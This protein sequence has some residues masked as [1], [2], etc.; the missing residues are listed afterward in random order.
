MAN[1]PCAGAAARRRVP[2]AGA[3]SVVA[4]LAFASPAHALD[5]RFEPSLSA[6]AIYTDNINQSSS[7]PQDGL[8]LS[9]TPGF[10]LQSKGSRRVQ[11]S[12]QY[13]LSGVTRFGGNQSDNFYHNL[14][15]VGKAELARDFLFI[16]GS[17]HI[18]QQ[19]ISLLG[20]PAD[21]T[22]NN[23]NRATVGTY[24]ISPYLQRRLGTFANAQMRYTASGAIFDN[25]AV[26]ANNSS[27]NAVTAGLASGTRFDDLTWGLDYSLRKA[28]YRS[29]ASTTFESA[30]ARLGYALTRK[31]RVFGTV[32]H[33]WNDYPS[34]TATSGASYSA[35]F[36]WAPSRRTSVEASAGKRYFGNTYSLSARHRTRMSNWN[37]SYSEDA[38]DITQFLFT[39]GTRYNYLCPDAQGNPQIITDWPYSFPPSSGCLQFGGTPGLMFDLRSGVFIARTARAGVSWGI[40]KVTYSLNY[41]DSRRMFVAANVEDRTQSLGATAIYRMTP[42]T[43]L[44]GG[45]TLTRTHMPAELVGTLHDDDLMIFSLGVSH[46]FAEKLDGALIFRHIKRDSNVATYGYDENNLMASVNMRF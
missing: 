13:G 19:L 7:N 30:S 42:R 26:N 6:S 45:L 31:F 46:S 44:N 34:L 5:W 41:S 8:I 3:F 40:R 36:G 9:A 4:A 24:S 21:A 2:A 18:S 25:Q 23:S 17:A 27:V 15:A 43:S 16:D 11:A 35:G 12:M 37:A 39:S 33:D 29:G 28:D 22:V 14:T 38:S 10:T 32:G 20:S 1:K